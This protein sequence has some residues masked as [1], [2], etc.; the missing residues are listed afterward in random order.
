MFLKK[1][2]ILLVM[3]GSLF[4]PTIASAAGKCFCSTDLSSA[5]PKSDLNDAAKWNAECFSWLGTTCSDYVKTRTVFTSCKETISEEAC[6]NQLEAWK[7]QKESVQTGADVYTDKY[8]WIGRAIPKC[9]FEDNLAE[10]CRNISVFVL[11]LINF[12]RGSITM[13]GGFAL[14]YFIY[15]GLILII[16]QGNPEKI[17]KGTDAMVAA[18]IGLII[19]FGAYLLISFLGQV[20]SVKEVYQL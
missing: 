7:K 19:V 5:T 12:A 8:G 14:I 10:S 17:K 9:V 6:V 11:L 18:A 1:N 2:I 4:L 20:V 16:S 13:I 15:G 3:L